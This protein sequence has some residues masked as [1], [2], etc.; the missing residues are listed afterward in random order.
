MVC[1]VLVIRVS[2]TPFISGKDATRLEDAQNFGVNTDA[3]WRVASG[4]DCV[5]TV[6]G[7]ILERQLHEVTLDNLHLACTL[8]SDPASTIE[9]LGAMVDSEAACEVVL[10]AENG[11]VE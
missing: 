11:T 6:K 10:V 3:V 8:P 7:V 5:Y 1:V 9:H 4:F 2:E